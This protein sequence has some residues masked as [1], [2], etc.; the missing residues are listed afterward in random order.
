MATATIKEAMLHGSGNFIQTE[1]YYDTWKADIG[2]Y[3][4]TRTT[5]K[6]PSEPYYKHTHKD[7]KA[8]ET[9]YNPLT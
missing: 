6:Q 4:E 1:G 2:K 3:E 9:S 8:K 7:I 5:W